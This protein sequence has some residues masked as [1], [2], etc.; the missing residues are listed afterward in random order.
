MFQSDPPL[1]GVRENRWNDYRRT[2]RTKRFGKKLS[3]R[4]IGEILNYR[5]VDGKSILL[6]RSG[7]NRC[8]AQ[9]DYEKRTGNLAYSQVN[10]EVSFKDYFV[11]QPE[12]F[13]RSWP[14]PKRYEFYKEK[15]YVPLKLG[16][17][18]TWC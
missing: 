13:K 8:Q 1:R 3:N 18:D 6:P 4:Q 9:K 12:S 16:N 2:A 17:P 15:K 7:S 5:P 11:C 14:G 10:G